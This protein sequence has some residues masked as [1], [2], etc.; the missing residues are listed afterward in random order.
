MEQSAIINAFIEL[1]N[2]LSNAIDHP[3]SESGKKIHQT[4]R[5]AI[6]ANRWFTEDSITQSMR[7]VISML[8][9]LKK[10]DV[11]NKIKYNEHPAIV[12]LIMAGN[13]PMVGFQDFLHVLLTGNIALCKLSDD[14]RILLPSLVEFL[15]DSEP[16]LKDYIRFSHGKISGFDAVIATGSN[17]TAR[18]FEY[19]FGKYEHIIRKNRNS[20][21]VLTGNESIEELSRLADDMFIY[22]GLGCRN[23]S[24][25]I[26]PENYDFTQLISACEKHFGCTSHTK[27][28]N[29]YDYYRA[30]HMVNV[31]PFIDGGFFILLETEIISSPPGIIHYRKYK[32]ISEAAAIVKSA[33]EQLQC[34]VSSHNEIPGAIPFGTTQQPELLDFA[35]GVNTIEFLN[36]LK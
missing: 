17:N 1:S 16:Q 7:G 15:T 34:V 5:L 24:S 36:S 27:Y 29:N 28:M 13:I 31:T 26:V 14:D 8:E 11:L 25:L 20:I 9:D 32:N 2:T 30:I 21:A 35:D 4:F 23:V 6:E 10:P 12:A 3:E 18:Y 19:Y 22:F 33:N